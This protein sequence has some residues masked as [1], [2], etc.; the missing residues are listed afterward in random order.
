MFR[1]LVVDH[2]P[3]SRRL[4]EGMLTGRAYSVRSASDRES[5]L[6]GFSGW[7]PHLVI[8]DVSASYV[9]GV[10]LCRRIR[11]VSSVPIIVVSAK[12]AEAAKVDALDSGADD[13]VTKPFGV[14]AL[15]GTTWFAG[16]GPGLV[17]MALA[18][19][20]VDYYFIPPVDSFGLTLKDVPSVLM[21]GASALFI[22]W[23]SAALRVSQQALRNARDQMEA[24]VQERTAE[25]AQTANL[26]DLTHDSVFVRDR[27]DVITY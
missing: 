8:A 4:L 23:V 16:V 24:K 14:N 19:A 17:A 20:V 3:Q 26:L 18:T 12:H 6:A 10:E 11:G 9:D 25:L 27:N 15:G 13:Y 21:F 1:V 2:E 7:Q 22:V 5:A